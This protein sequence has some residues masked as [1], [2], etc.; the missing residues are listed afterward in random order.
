[1]LE[2]LDAVDPTDAGVVIIAIYRAVS[3]RDQ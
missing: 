2:E 1:M 3:K